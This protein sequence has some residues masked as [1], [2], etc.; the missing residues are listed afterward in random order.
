MY[1]MD[2]DKPLFDVLESLKTKQEGKPVDVK[3]MNDEAVRDLFAEVLPDFDRDRVYTT[4]IRKLYNWYNQL[5]AAGITDFKE[6][7]EAAEEQA[8]ETAEGAE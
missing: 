2:G 8:G 7:E 1:T 5:I 3:A 6:E 4:D